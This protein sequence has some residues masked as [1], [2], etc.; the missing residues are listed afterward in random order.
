MSRNQEEMEEYR[1][2]LLEESRQEEME[3]YRLSSDEDY[4]RDSLL[5]EIEQFTEAYYKIKKTYEAY[6]WEF[7][8]DDILNG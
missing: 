1:Q 4:I 7:D 5:D 2:E 8:V 6:G 3:E